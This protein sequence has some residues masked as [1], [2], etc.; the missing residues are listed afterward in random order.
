MQQYL[1]KYQNKKKTKKYRFYQYKILK[2]YETASKLNHVVRQGRIYVF[3]LSS[4]A[5]DKLIP[6]VVIAVLKK[7]FYT[8]LL[9]HKVQI[10]KSNNATH[11][12]QPRQYILG[13]ILPVTVRKQTGSTATMNK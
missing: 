4:S 8:L 1:L 13:R 11:S 10:C 9:E 5:C 3:N 12:R 2:Q 7:S 6:R